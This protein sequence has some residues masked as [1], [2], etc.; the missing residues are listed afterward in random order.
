[1]KIGKERNLSKAQQSAMNRLK[2]DKTIVIVPADKGRAVVVLNKTD[3]NEKLQ[4][5]LEDTTSTIYKPIVDKRCNPNTRTE[6][7][8]NKLLFDIRKQK[9]SHDPQKS[10]LSTQLYNHLHSTDAS[11]ATFY[12]LPKIHKPSIPLRLHRLSNLY[13]TCQNTLHR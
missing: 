7:E 6:K 2:K 5:L 9:A 8:L 4:T 10:Q 13:I 3:Y 12:G 1:M 11:P